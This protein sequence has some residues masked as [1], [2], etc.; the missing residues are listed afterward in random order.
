M[1]VAGLVQAIMMS[2]R[3]N[4]AEQL[5]ALE[6]QA[7]LARSQGK[8]VWLKTAAKDA[9]SLQFISATWIDKHLCPL[10]R[11]T[12]WVVESRACFVDVR[13]KNNP[14][15]TAV[16]ENAPNMVDDVASL[17]ETQEDV[18]LDY[19]DDLDLMED[20]PRPMLTNQVSLPPPKPVLAEVNTAMSEEAMSPT[21]TTTV[22]THR[23]S[24]GRDSH[25]IRLPGRSGAKQK[26]RP[27]SDSPVTPQ[28]PAPCST[29]RSE[30]RRKVTPVPSKRRNG[31]P[32]SWCDAMEQY[33][34]PKGH[35]YARHIPTGLHVQESGR[36]ATQR[37]MAALESVAASWGEKD[38]G[39]FVK[40]LNST[41][42][43][44]AIPKVPSSMTA[45]IEALNKLL[46]WT[47]T[48][49]GSPISS[50]GM[51][52]HWEVLQELLVRLT[53]QQYAA[54]Q[55]QYNILPEEVDRRM[56]PAEVVPS[57]VSFSACS[58]SGEEEEEEENWVVVDEVEKLSE[59]FDSHFHLDRLQTALGVGE[60]TLEDI[61]SRLHPS[62]TY[63][64][65]VV[66][67]VAN[68]CDPSTY[69]DATTISHLRKQGVRITVG[70]HPKH[71][72]RNNAPALQTLSQLIAH[73]EVVGVGEVG[74]DQSVPVEEW[75]RQQDLLQD[76]LEK[77]QPHHVLVLHCRGMLNLDS[78]EAYTTL[79]YQCVGVVPPE[80]P[81]TSTW[82]H[83]DDTRRRAVDFVAS[84]TSTLDLPPWL[85]VSA[86]S[87]RPLSARWT[88]IRSCW[89][90]TPH[91][92]L[93]VDANTPRQVSSSSS[94][95]SSA[96]VRGDSLGGG[97]ACV[98]GEWAPT[99]QLS[100]RE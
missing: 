20:Q 89:R 47:E 86:R 2:V 29:V 88:A 63:E 51:L 25:S 35:M 27:Q 5:A 93:L 43:F 48:D 17:L 81:S 52:L 23:Q 83:R 24:A 61:H 11:Q 90:R 68:F 78:K 6:G 69:P 84:G 19:E 33:R 58:T 28:K 22:E 53:N 71:P 50:P 44:A 80:Q 15:L 31:C 1:G 72:R 82:F 94:L 40:M 59:A 97:S 65:D 76:V 13:L 64:V 55:R 67:A 8:T 34:Y 62:D 60:I 26:R 4:S 3:K 66:G 87:R 7:Q 36:A 12:P 32:I 49:R 41:G 16:R 98:S 38:L 39:S 21:P 75:S 18:E 73:P 45:S 57:G 79:M 100:P 95:R 85:P 30:K 9:E 46:V 74:I 37:R 10:Q 70:L 92:F 91:T 99:V 54:L 56:P 96:Q 14:N 77:L 42:W